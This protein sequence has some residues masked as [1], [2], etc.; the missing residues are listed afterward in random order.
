MSK[1]DHKVE[2]WT[3]D[4]AKTELHTTAEK[5]RRC[6]DLPFIDPQVTQV[7]VTPPKQR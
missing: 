3:T 1:K 7:T 4:G 2:I 5:A 6:E